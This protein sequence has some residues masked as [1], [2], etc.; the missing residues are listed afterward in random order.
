MSGVLKHKHQ[1]SPNFV[2]LRNG[3]DSFATRRA[4]VD[5]AQS[6]IDAQY[7]IWHNDLSGSAL[8]SQLL[9]AAERG[10]KVRLLLGDIKMGGMRSILKTI[11]AHPLVKVRPFKPINSE[12]DSSAWQRFLI[13]VLSIFSLN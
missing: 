7:Y 13:S 1:R 3:R 11:D 8:L 10:V 6:T 2:L 9:N 4:L 12:G 5:L